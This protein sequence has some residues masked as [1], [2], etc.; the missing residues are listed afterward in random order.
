VWSVLKYIF[1]GELNPTP[2]GKNS[3]RNSYQEPARTS[4]MVIT[5][6]PAALTAMVKALQSQKLKGYKVIKMN[7]R[8]GENKPYEKR[9]TEVL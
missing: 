2:N 5:D 3:G 6:N 4:W 7:Y 9:T 1:V 8:K